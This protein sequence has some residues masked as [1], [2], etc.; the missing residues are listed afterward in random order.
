MNMV[1]LIPS[2][3]NE[4]T[5]ATIPVYVQEAVKDCQVFF[6]ENA[7]TARR[8]L[9]TI[10]KEMII[11]HYEWFEIGKSEEQVI[12]SF[13]QKIKEGKNIGIISEAGCPGVADPGQKLIGVAQDMNATVRPLVGPSSILLALMASGMNGQQFTF[14]G[15]LPI[16]TQHRMQAI[17][18]MENDAAKNNCTQIFIET[19]YRNN[20]LL[21]T[22]LKTCRPQTRLCV[23]ADI[24]GKDEMIRTKTIEAWKK[25]KPELHKI[26][27]IFLLIA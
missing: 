4:E 17:R 2:V 20:Q 26:P 5:T 18:Q 13:R 15:Y 1:Y 9:K 7:R 21:E 16:D 8:F 27:A 12:S 11:D 24:T 10:W 14:R 23:A 25:D 19:P 6:V 22:L 3:L